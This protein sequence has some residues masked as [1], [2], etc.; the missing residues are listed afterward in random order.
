MSCQLHA[1][2]IAACQRLLPCG[3]HPYTYLERLMAAS[4]S[5]LPSCSLYKC[6][7]FS[8]KM[9]CPPSANPKLS[10]RGTRPREERSTREVYILACAVCAA[11]ESSTSR[12]AATAAAR[13]AMSAAATLASPRWV[14]HG[15]N[16]QFWCA[17]KV[18]L[19]VEA[20]RCI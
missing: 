7:S 15:L 19:V 14:W 12:V 9:S 16:L 18:E 3:H 2:C 4:C 13:P 11:T 6:R 1:A 20:W 17:R 10:V 5:L 8:V